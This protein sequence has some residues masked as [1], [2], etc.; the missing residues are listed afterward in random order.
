MCLVVL[1]CLGF[2]RCPT[3]GSLRTGKFHMSQCNL[4]LGR[5]VM[6]LATIH[7]PD[8]VRARDKLNDRAPP[9]RRDQHLTFHDMMDKN[10]LRRAGILG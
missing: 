7:V 9:M 3:G 6:P 2:E 1:F 4:H 10:R 8:K 5:R